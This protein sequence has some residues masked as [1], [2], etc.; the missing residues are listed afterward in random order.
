MRT[1]IALFAAATLAAICATSSRVEAY[2]GAMCF[3]GDGCGRC[4]VCVKAQPT[5]PT[6]T[7]LKIAGCY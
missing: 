3:S 7:C 6:G 1:L 2:P 4:E 5:D